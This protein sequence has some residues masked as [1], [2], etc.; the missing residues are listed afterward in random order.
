MLGAVRRRSFTHTASAAITSPSLTPGVNGGTINGGNG[1]ISITW[2]APTPTPS[3]T[4]PSMLEG[5]ADPGAKPMMNAGNK[6][7]T[8]T[9]PD[10]AP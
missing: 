4:P 2:I 6:I 1:Q 7:T 3:P 8:L 10:S 9:G 5:L